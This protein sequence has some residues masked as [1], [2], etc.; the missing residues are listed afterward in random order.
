LFPIFAWQKKKEGTQMLLT[1]MKYIFK[2][3]FTKS[4][5]VIF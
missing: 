1:C 4:N 3:L 5:L 2:T